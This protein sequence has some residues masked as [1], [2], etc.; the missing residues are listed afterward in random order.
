[1]KPTFNVLDRGW[2]PVVCEDGTRKLLGIRQTLAQA[3]ELR[4]IS[5]PSTL[6]E[7][8]L[9]RFL[10]LFLMDALRPGKK[11]S[12]RALLQEGKFDMTQIEAYIA[13]CQSEGVS[14]DLF[15]EKRPFLQSKFDPDDKDSKRPAFKLDCSFPAESGH[16]HFVHDPFG[17]SRFQPDKAARSMLASYVFCFSAGRGYYYSVYGAPPL[18]GVITGDNLYETL[19]A[20]LLPLDQ[21]SDFDDPPVLWRNPEP[22]IP[23]RKV[24]K[25]SWLLGMLFPARKIQLIP[26]DD[27]TVSEVFYSGGVKFENPDSWR[28]PYATYRAHKDSLKPLLPNGKEAIW[29][30][31]CD[32]VNTKHDHASRLL[33][34]YSQLH[35]HETTR[36][37]M[38]GI[39]ADD[40]K[41]LMSCRY[42][43]SLP[44]VLIENES[45]EELLKRAITNAEQIRNALLF[46]FEIPKKVDLERSKEKVFFMEESFSGRF[47]GPN[48]KTIRYWAPSYV[49]ESVSGRFEAFCQNHILQMCNTYS[50]RETLI[51]HVKAFMTEAS[52]YAKILFEESFKGTK[53]SAKTQALI[54]E[55]ETALRAYL[56]MLQINCQQEEQ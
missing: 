21:I 52:E 23:G 43:L 47:R 16:T 42:D 53:V 32:I 12:I 31:I 35:R 56:F 18:F 24:G 44:A 45:V 1:M 39:L 51:Y 25:T 9:Y 29:R 36:M 38:Y 20:E 46:A 4:E 10:G 3:H 7:Y 49:I 30:N 50:S 19:V 26:N 28:D 22:I 27:G 34:F 33:Q 37:I 6:D 14:F 17:A 13:Q 54:V 11:S 15:D 41:I 2:I 48:A 55:K 8:S 5:D 40:A